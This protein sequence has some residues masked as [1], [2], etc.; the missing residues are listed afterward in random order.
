MLSVIQDRLESLPPAERRV[1]NWILEHPRSAARATLAEL[2]ENCGSSEPTVIRFC[3]RIGLGGFRELALRLTEAM[4]QP[5]S[6]IHQDVQADDFPVDAATKVVDSSIQSLFDI[7]AHLTAMPIETAVTAMASA[8]QLVFAGLGASGHVAS[9]AC[10]KFFRLGLPCM[11]LTDTPSILQF[12]AIA[13][14]EDVLLITSHSGRWPE[15]ARAASSARNRGSTVIA[16]TGAST[17]LARQASIL[18]PINAREDT[19]IYTPM[20]SRLAHLALLDALQVG[21]T[22]HIGDSAVDKL[23]LSKNALS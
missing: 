21:L 11:A 19:S 17:E 3:R 1:A 18:F 14:P 22:L 2:A 15:V 9:D 10:H 20:S 6:Y 23:R 13:A 12:A 5:A 7:R 16:I 8:R 4:S